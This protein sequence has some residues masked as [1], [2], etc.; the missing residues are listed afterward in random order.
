[1]PQVIKVGSRD[2][3]S[4]FIWP[5]LIT[6]I[7][8][9][10]FW[11]AWKPNRHQSSSLYSRKLNTP[12][13]A[14][15]VLNL[16]Y[17]KSLKKKTL[18]IFRFPCSYSYIILFLWIRHTEVLFTLFTKLILLTWRIWWAPT[19]ASKWRIGI[20]S[21]FKGLNKGRGPVKFVHIK[22]VVHVLV[23]ARSKACYWDG[24]LESRW[25]H[26]CSSL[27][28]VVALRPTSW[29]SFAGD[30]PVA[31]YFE[32]STTM[33]TKS[34]LGCRAARRVGKGCCYL[35]CVQSYLRRGYAMSSSGLL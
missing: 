11:H 16:Q 8:S 3:S 23:A 20:S 30:L 4:Q 13:Q 35:L 34:Q 19:N 33:R 18:N 2:N 29:S 24:R 6:R 14:Y 17:L 21:A 7:H 26:E 5:T 10:I 25:R 28:F 22:S 9:S 12:I 31:C 32:I 15:N 1:M 27:G